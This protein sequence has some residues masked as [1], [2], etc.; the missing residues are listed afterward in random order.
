MPRLSVVITTKNEEAHIANC[1]HAFDDYVAKGLCEVIVVDNFSTDKT[2]S[3]AREL[4]ASVISYGPERS[5]QRNKGWQES[6]SDYVMI[7]DADMIVPRGTIDE[8]LSLI[9]ERKPSGLYVK[10]NRVGSGIRIRARNFERSFYD[11]T[12][13]DALRVFDKSLL[14]QVGGYDESFTGPEDWDL[15][16]KILSVSTN[17]ALTKGYL[18]HNEKNLS[19]RQL[20]RKKNYYSHGISLYKK[21]WG[22]DEVVRKQLGFAYRYFGVYVEN[23][24]WKK[25]LRH[26]ILFTVMFF[27]RICVGIVYLTYSRS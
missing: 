24:K 14:L 12:V 20:L 1:I 16:R 17:V 26:P 7:L 10:E 6:S 5:A 18:I 4:G 3:I 23:G 9:E 25:I 27:E 22:N 2:E 8:I 21:K 19:L 15:D 13:I 11:A